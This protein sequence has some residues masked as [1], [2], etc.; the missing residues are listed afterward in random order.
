MPLRLNTE[1]LILKGCRWV[2]NWTIIQRLVPSA[3]TIF[4][5][6]TDVDGV[7]PLSLSSAEQHVLQSVD[8][9]RDV[10]AVARE[11]SMT[12]FEAS[13]VF[14]CLASV[15]L[16]RTADL[17]K[18]RLRRAFRELAE[19]VC[20]ST[21]AWRSS[22]SDRIC[23]EEVNQLCRHLHLGLDEGRIKDHAEPHLK[24]EELGEIHGAFLLAQLEV[25]SR[26]FGRENGRRSFARTLS[27]LAPELQ[28]VAKRYG[29]DKLQAE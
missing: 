21:V 15:R 29:F 7:V 11:L 22:P 14:C 16:V 10:A 23:E 28:D 8:G 13:R 6:V 27:Q 17:D 19:L 9:V 24:T 18:I 5:P 2:D 12:L 20:S 1:D 4:E 3:D 25:V 26:R